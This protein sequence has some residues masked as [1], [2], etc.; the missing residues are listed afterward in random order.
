[1]IAL[2]TEIIMKIHSSWTV[3]FDSDLYEAGWTEDGEKFIAETYYVFISTPAIKVPARKRT[4]LLSVFVNPNVWL[5][6]SK[7]FFYYYCQYIIIKIL[8]LTMR[9]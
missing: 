4:T 7:N 1:M 3:D 6:L 8:C 2:S 9:G 5:S